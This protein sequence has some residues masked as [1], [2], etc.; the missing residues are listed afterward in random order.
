MKNYYLL[1]I[2]LIIPFNVLIAT[3]PYDPGESYKDDQA[4]EEYLET[5][6]PKER[7]EIEH[8]WDFCPYCPLLIMVG[9]FVIYF[10]YSKYKDPY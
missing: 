6:S 3:N 2:F 5:L 1:I 4:Y 10:L 8:F 7:Y 9:I